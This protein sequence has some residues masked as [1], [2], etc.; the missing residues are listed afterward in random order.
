M[1]SDNKDI[2]NIQKE[3]LF[4]LKKFHML[5]IKNNIKYTLH[6]GSMLGAIREKGFI[7]WDDDA[8]IALL[9]SEYSKL[10]KC[11]SMDASEEMYLDNFSDKMYKVWMKR[12]GHPIV[13]I[14]IFVYDF[15]SEK[16]LFQKMK[17][18]GIS[19]LTPF[20]KNEVSI[21][22][23]RA[24]GRANG[25]KKYIYE[26]LYCCGKIFPQ[27][28]KIK[29]IDFFEQKTF[30]GNKKYIHRSNDQL[31]AMK[32]IIKTDYMRKYVLKK[33]EDTELM[34]S[35]NYNEILVSSYGE[36]YMTPKK[37]QENDIIHAIARKNR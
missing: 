35:E 36:D 23:F 20:V 22:Q 11:I 28:Q 26:F 9:R 29:L 10:C 18:M 14:D 33:F 30:K 34:V 24:N 12:T 32:M 13:W 1:F 27:R 15:I 17:I 7:Q 31:F 16:R 4:L 8:D 37:N 21:Q 5:C 25:V 3:I 19:L 6:G 2:K